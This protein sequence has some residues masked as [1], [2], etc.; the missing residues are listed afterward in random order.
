MSELDNTTRFDHTLSDAKGHWVYHMLRHT[1]GDSL[2]FDTCRRIVS[3]YTEEQITLDKMRM[4]FI[5]AA[6]SIDLEQF[7]AQWLDRTGAPVIDL[8]WQ[9]EKQMKDNPYVDSQ[10]ES[11]IIGEEEPPFEVT[12]ELEQ[13]QAGEPYVLDLEVEIEFVDGSTQL[14]TVPMDAR[15][16]KTTLSVDALPRE[17]RLDPNRKTLL[18]RPVYGPRPDAEVVSA[19]TPAQ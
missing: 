17:I 7:F 16:A 12:L 4:E 14:E 2:F 5:A 10:L 1:M 19:G 11:V 18:W 6:P 8:R 15:Q 3:R 13:V 9:L